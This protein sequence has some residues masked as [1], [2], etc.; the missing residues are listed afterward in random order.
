MLQR[1]EDNWVLI[2]VQYAKMSLRV[3]AS[4]V[5]CHAAKPPNTASGRIRCSLVHVYAIHAGVKLCV[6]VTLPVHFPAVQMPIMPI[7]KRE[8]KDS[9]HCHQ[10]GWNYHRKYGIL[11][12]KN[13]VSFTFIIHLVHF[14]ISS[15]IIN[16]IGSIFIKIIIILKF[17]SH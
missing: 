6:V 14:Y 16:N 7:I 1:V 17:A 4:L 11:L 5:H 12:F 8:L 3:A 10:N 2:P 13:F 9:G 15:F